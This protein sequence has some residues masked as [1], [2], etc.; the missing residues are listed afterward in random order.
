MVFFIV[1][2]E[3]TTEED[4]PLS[5]NR[6]FPLRKSIKDSLKK[7]R[8]KFKSAN[9]LGASLAVNEENGEIIED[10]SPMGSSQNMSQLISK[11]GIEDS[12]AR[13]FIV[14]IFRSPPQASVKRILFFTSFFSER[15]WQSFGLSPERLKEVK[16]AL[17]IAQ[18]E[19]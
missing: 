10:L 15:E 8:R 7:A 2:T 5:N 18:N 11:K 19:L 17:R 6:Q 9:H 13:V 4:E 14:I 12:I 3:A 16:L 1:I